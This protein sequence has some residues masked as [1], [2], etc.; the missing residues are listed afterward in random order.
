MYIWEKL[1][2][3]RCCRTGGGNSKYSRFSWG[4]SVPQPFVRDVSVTQSLVLSHRLQNRLYR[5]ICEF[6]KCYPGENHLCCALGYLCQWQ[7]NVVNSWELI[8]IRAEQ[9]KQTNRWFVCSTFPAQL[10]VWA[11]QHLHRGRKGWDQ[12]GPLCWHKVIAVMGCVC[13]SCRG[14]SC[15][16]C[17]FTAVEAAP[18][19]CGW[20]CPGF[21]LQK[22]SIQPAVSSGGWGLHAWSSSEIV[23]QFF[24]CPEGATCAVPL[25]AWIQGSLPWKIFC[26]GFCALLC[27]FLVDVLVGWWPA[28]PRKH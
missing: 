21:L 11:Q 9:A 3:Y 6:L 26:S 2:C 18:E 24:L 1:M 4:W 23:A 13:V 17:C 15:V 14:F 20:L 28:L 16:K 5:L 19:W 25:R 27:I 22:P 10:S 8:Q 12:V 7:P